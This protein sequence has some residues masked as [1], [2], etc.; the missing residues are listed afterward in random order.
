MGLALA[1][2]AGAGGSANAAPTVVPS[3]FHDGLVFVSLVVGAGPPGVFLLDTGAAVTVLDIR[4]A[5]A[6]H[7]KLGDPIHIVG[8]GGAA[9]ARQAENVAL[10][11]A[12]EPPL[13]ADPVVADL[14]APSQAM[15][16]HL[17]GI[18]GDDVLRRFVLTLD[19]RDQAV[20]LSQAEPAPADAVAMR[21]IATPYVAATIED[22]GR[23]PAAAFQIDT[24]ANTAL[25]FWAPFAAQ[26]LAPERTRPALGV[27][28]AGDT[29][30]QIGH[31]EAL[32]VAGRR[33]LGPKADFADQLHPDDAGPDYG[34]V[35]GGPAWAGLV[36]TLDFPHRRVWVR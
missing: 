7:V 29:R 5:D 22:A 8:G 3:Q 19:Y 34:G 16:R 11:L 28:V 1:A 21:L 2:L 13:F 24:G 33:I 20:R 26:A 35:I 25:A 31:V 36:L 4:F 23:K 32:D 30:G 17:D 27:G 15:G 6:A 10:T 12:G 18:L 9:Q 14:G